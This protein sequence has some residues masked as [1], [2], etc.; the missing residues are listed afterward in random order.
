[1][2]TIFLF[3]II[4]NIHRYFDFLFKKGYVIRRT[5]YDFTHF[6]NWRVVL[7]S[8]DCLIEIYQDRDEIFLAFAPKNGSQEN[9]IGIEP[10]V[11]FISHGDTFIGWYDGNLAWD[12]RQQFKRLARLLEEYVDLITPYFGNEF[13]KYAGDLILAQKNYNKLFLEKYSSRQI[14]GNGAR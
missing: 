2:N 1:M 7:E 9:L 11:Y 3:C 12:K 4:Q 5:D 13:K 10:M 6:G 8:V 14:Q